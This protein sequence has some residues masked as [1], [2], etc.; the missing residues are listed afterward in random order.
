MC[1]VLRT[2]HQLFPHSQQ[3]GPDHWDLIVKSLEVLTLLSQFLFSYIIVKDLCL[4]FLLGA[5]QN[6]S[7]VPG[8]GIGKDLLRA[9]VAAVVT[10]LGRSL[11]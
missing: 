7:H 9:A 11:E 6:A 8:E 10:Q 5:F 2:C 3:V 4:F 1:F